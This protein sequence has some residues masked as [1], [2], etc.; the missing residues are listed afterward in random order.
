MLSKQNDNTHN[1]KLM[2]GY[3]PASLS[4]FEYGINDWKNIQPQ[5]NKLIDLIIPN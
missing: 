4:I 1:N 5:G 2:F 3:P